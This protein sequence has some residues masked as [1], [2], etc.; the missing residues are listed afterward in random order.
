VFRVIVGFVLGRSRIETSAI[1]IGRQA[2]YRYRVCRPR[3]EFFA[4]S[5]RKKEPQLFNSS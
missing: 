1:L 5:K 3:A 2:A 4:D